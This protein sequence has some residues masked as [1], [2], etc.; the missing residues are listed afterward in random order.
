[1][2]GFTNWARAGRPGAWG[3]AAPMVRALV[4]FFVW[5]QSAC[6][7]L[8]CSAGNVTLNYGSYDVLSGAELAVAGSFTVSCTAT[9]RTGNSN[10]TYTV[11]L[12]PLSPR[13]LAP[14]SG[15]DRLTDEFY[16]DSA[17]TQPWGD[18]TAGTF[19]FT[20][21]FY[22]RRRRTTTDV[23]INFYALITPGGQDV[24]AASPGPPPTTYTE[25]LTITVTCT[26]PA[27][28]C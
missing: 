26:S 9:G 24:S 27:L 17:R 13:E 18:G 10:V 16:V 20:N 23:P 14:P 25:T 3:R 6:A 28:S 2:N 19:V 15:T 1:M 7:A 21:T 5:V 4:I 8:S 22:V 11:G 12:T